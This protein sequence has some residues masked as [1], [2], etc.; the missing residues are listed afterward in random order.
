MAH[1]MMDRMAHQLTAPVL[2]LQ[3][4]TMQKGPAKADRMGPVARHQMLRI[5]TEGYDKRYILIQDPM[6]SGC[7]RS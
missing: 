4:I 7:R 3:E 1:Q 5:L 2:R 6:D